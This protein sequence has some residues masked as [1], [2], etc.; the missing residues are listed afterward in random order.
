MNLLFFQCFKL[1]KNCS[2]RWNKQKKCSKL[3][4]W[5]V[6]QHDT[7][8]DVTAS[9]G[10]AIIIWVI[11]F[12]QKSKCTTFSSNTQAIHYWC[13]RSSLVVVQFHWYTFVGSGFARVEII[14]FTIYSSHKFINFFLLSMV[15]IYQVIMNYSVELK[16]INKKSTSKSII[17]WWLRNTFFRFTFQISHVYF[18]S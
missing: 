11:R 10:M 8:M 2:R 15:F 12:A 16:W 9:D 1:A 5:I 13:N 18:T 6:S 4:T 7:F 17:N 14:N 3:D